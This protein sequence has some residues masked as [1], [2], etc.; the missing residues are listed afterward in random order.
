MKSTIESRNSK[1][2][3][4][5]L[6][7]HALSEKIAR[8]TGSNESQTTA[9]SGLTLFRRESPTGPINGLYEPSLCLVAQGSKRVLLGEDT[10]L[11][12]KTP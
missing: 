1:E 10:Y 11:Y 2:Y 6:S 8:W 9:I 12:L 7:M 4:Q 5:V 3:E